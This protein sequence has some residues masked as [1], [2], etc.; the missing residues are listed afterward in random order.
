MGFCPVRKRYW[1]GFKKSEGGGGSVQWGFGLD[2]V[3]H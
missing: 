1:G 2:T 3:N